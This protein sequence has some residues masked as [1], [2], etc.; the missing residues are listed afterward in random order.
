MVIDLERDCERLLLTEEQEKEAYRQ[1]PSE[2]LQT[3]YMF[4]DMIQ[5]RNKVMDY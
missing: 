5:W 1:S 3:R 4:F 2:P